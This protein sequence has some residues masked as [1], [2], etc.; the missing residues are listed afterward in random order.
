M[1]VAA[2]ITP[3]QRAA[4]VRSMVDRLA[5]RLKTQPN[6]LAGWQQLADSY[7]TLGDSV[8]ARDA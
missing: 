2:N 1:E 8:G 4:F 6:D 7:H 5:E 3:E